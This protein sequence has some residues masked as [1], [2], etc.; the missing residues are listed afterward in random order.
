M[1]YYIGDD[2]IAGEDD[3][4]SA[5][6]IGRALRRV[7]RGR[8]GPPAGIMRTR[9]TGIT[10]PYGQEVLAHQREIRADLYQVFGLGVVTNALAGAF[11]LSQP[12]V[13]RFKPGRLLLTETAPGNVVNIITIGVRP[14]GANLAAM[15]VAGFGAGAFETRIAFDVGEI[16]QPFSVQ[17]T[18][19]LAAQTVAGMA[20]GTTIKGVG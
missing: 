6:E 12:F 14:Q 10:T 20:Y 13:E 2:D 7:M 4:V 16:G 17:G 1:S 18:T 5:E 11:T 3:E 8:K 9:P 19:T 15:P